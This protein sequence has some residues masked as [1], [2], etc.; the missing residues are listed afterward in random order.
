MANSLICIDA[1]LVVRLVV[2]TADNRLP[3]QWKEWTQAGTQIAAPSLLFYEVTNALY[4]YQQHGFLNPEIV[5]QALNAALSLPIN[6]YTGSAYHL[7][8][9]RI[10][11]RF[12]LPATY[13]AH[14][15]AVAE[16]LEAEFWSAD[17]RLAQ[18]VQPQLNW[19]RL[20]P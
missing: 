5:E 16:H 19:F 7:T 8:A 13:G 4:Q 14:Y 15:L 12:A 1:S 9:V 3:E 2:D 17:R 20:Y 11:K 18:K 6:L 10:A